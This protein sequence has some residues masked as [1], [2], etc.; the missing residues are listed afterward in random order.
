MEAEALATK[1]LID[2]SEAE[3]SETE[4]DCEA[5]SDAKLASESEIWESG[6]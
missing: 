5:F 1:S 6:S 3:V 2:A 4:T